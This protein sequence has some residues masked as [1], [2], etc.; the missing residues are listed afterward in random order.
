MAIVALITIGMTGAVYAETATVEIP[1]DS[2]GSTC[3]FDELSV[4]FHCVWQGFKEVY[5]LEDLE[6]YKDLLTAERY[7]Q[8]IQKLNEQALA[9]IAE[10]KAKLT[11]NEKTIQEIE[12]KLAKGIATVTDSVYMNL[13]KELNTCKQGMDRQTAPFQEAREFE[14]SEFNLWQVNNVPVEGHLGDLVM[15]VE[16]CRG[17]QKLLKVVGEGYSSMPTGED[18]KQFSLLE[19]FEGVQ[20]LNFDDH[21]AT[22]RNIDKSLICG[23][24]Q[25]PLT[26]QAQFGCEVLYDGKTVEQI[27]AE[28]EARFGTDGKIHY[29]SE[30]LGEYHEFMKSYGNKVATDEDKANAE[31]LAEPIA[32]EMIMNN[33][34]VQNQIRNGE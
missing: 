14:I 31:K 27:K 10:E 21:T 3:T 9:E 29:Q 12:E 11:P 7:D 15:A 33:N 13:L 20:A 24:N 23:N 4:E 25:F 6:N 26:H 17:Q 1:F 34:F 2:H 19:H 16:E 32:Y 30:L 8:E 28:N 18:D 5:T 22:H